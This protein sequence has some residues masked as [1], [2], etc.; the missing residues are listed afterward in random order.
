MIAL[1]SDLLTRVPDS[2]LILKSSLASDRNAQQQL[3]SLFVQNGIEASRIEILSRL[4][5]FSEHLKQYQRVDIALDT[6]PY[7]GTT[8]TCEA[9]WMGVPVITLAGNTHASRVGASILSRLG[10]NEWIISSIDDYSNISATLANDIENLKYLRRTLREKFQNSSL[11]NE[12]RF[13]VKLE[14]AYRRMWLNRCAN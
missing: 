12:K 5:V 1:W 7:N 2:R 13:M 11:M 4:P 8:T 10:L 6:F 14:T 3:L 9:L